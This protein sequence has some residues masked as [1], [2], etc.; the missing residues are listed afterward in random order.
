MCST[1]GE[2]FDS[3][4]DKLSHLPTCGPD[5][6][7]R[8]KMDKFSTS[9]AAGSASQSSNTNSKPEILDDL[10]QHP[11]SAST[12]SLHD[13][14]PVAFGVDPDAPKKVKLPKRRLR[15]DTLKDLTEGGIPNGAVLRDR[16]EAEQ[17][18]IKQNSV[19][20]KSFSHRSKAQSCYNI[21]LKGD[22][23]SND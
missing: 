4:Q 6:P 15:P 9:A 20:V 11:S 10:S 2:L 12:V 3:I 1:C 22:D 21:R 18:M 13:N 23:I 14:H 19:C 5:S 8:H 16:P 17:E 7:K